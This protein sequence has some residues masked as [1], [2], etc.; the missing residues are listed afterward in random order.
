MAIKKSVR[1]N[2]R[3]HA[4]TFNLFPLAIFLVLAVVFYIRRKMFAIPD[5]EID[6]LVEKLKA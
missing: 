2:Y 5:G 1:K 6:G 4:A 3:L